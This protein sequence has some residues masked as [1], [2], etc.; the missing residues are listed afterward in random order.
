MIKKSFLNDYTGSMMDL[1]D[2]DAVLFV[3]KG[4]VAEHMLSLQKKENYRKDIKI[5]NPRCG[6]LCEKECTDLINKSVNENYGKYPVYFTYIFQF[7]KDSEYK[8]VPFGIIYKV[9]KKGGEF[10]P[11]FDP[12]SVMHIDTGIVTKDKD[13]LDL[14]SAYRDR[15]GWYYLSVNDLKKADG[16]YEKLYD[17]ANV[18]YI[19][20]AAMFF[21]KTGRFDTALKYLDKAVSIQPDYYL[22]Y[23]NKAV[24]Y[25][26]KGNKKEALDNYIIF[27]NKCASDPHL[28]VYLD[29][30]LK[31]I[32]E[33]ETELN[34]G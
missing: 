30:A 26:Y 11:G 4:P 18:E 7:D 9:L 1:T 19:N 28:K 22:T 16:C 20:D 15:M 5:L 32:K 23:Y 17:S 31:R 29:A 10:K 21:L 27:F 12:G 6:K 8:L 13:I 2:K 14:I 24:V 34:N 25:D 33:L 3:E